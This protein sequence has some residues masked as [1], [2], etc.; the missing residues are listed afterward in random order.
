M[1]YKT[2][3]K[4]K[5][6]KEKYYKLHRQ[7]STSQIIAL[8]HVSKFNEEMIWILILTLECQVDSEQQIQRLSVIW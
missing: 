3:K 2:V 6:L 4:K 5:K 7:F 1:N 8:R